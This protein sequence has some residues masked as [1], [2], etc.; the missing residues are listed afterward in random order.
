MQLRATV[1][2][3]SDPTKT[4]PTFIVLRPL[5]TLY[6][7]QQTIPAIPAMAITIQ[8]ITRAFFFILFARLSVVG[9]YDF[10]RV[11]DQPP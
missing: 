3:E 9:L 4:P 5:P 6:I 11:E 7:C 8:K 2:G 10:H 1:V